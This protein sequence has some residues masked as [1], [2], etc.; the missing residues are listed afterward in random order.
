MISVITITSNRELYLK[1]LLESFWYLGG[2]DKVDFEYFLVFQG[3]PPSPKI[4]Q[5]I[6]QLPFSDNIKVSHFPEIRPI[7]ER[8]TPI[9]EQVKFPIIFK[10][11]DDCVLSSMDFFPRLFELTTKLPK[12]FI[13]PYL[14]AGETENDVCRAEEK[15]LYLEKNN[16]YITIAKAV[17]AS[18][19]YV[20]P[21]SL[22]K[23]IIFKGQNDAELIQVS[24][25]YWKIPIYQVKNGLVIE[26]QEGYSGQHYR[27]QMTNGQSW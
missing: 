6:K 15:V 1:R 2:C 3:G 5:Y 25:I 21:I 11:D 27:K 9:I 14:I 16:L 13:Y 26:N 12:C 20:M 23:E 19:K 18:G 4:N 24:S 22:A 17:F 8:L 10:I 7:G